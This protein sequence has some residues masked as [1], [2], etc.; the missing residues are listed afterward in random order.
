M[1]TLRFSAVMLQRGINPFV[2]I[3]AAQATELKPGWRKPMPVRV[4]INGKPRTPWCINLMPVGNG[5]FYLYLRSDVRKA[6]GTKVGRRVKLEI[7][8]DSASHGGPGALPDWFEAALAKDAEAKA[9]WMKL[10]PGRQKE[11]ARYL[12]SLKSPEARS[13]NL[14][15][16]LGVLSEKQGR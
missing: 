8:F 5:S 13:P 4:R 11:I 9:A 14:A 2:L 6:S 7:A 15:R 1:S 10:T 12:A 16:A 3:S